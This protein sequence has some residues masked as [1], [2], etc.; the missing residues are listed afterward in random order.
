MVRWLHGRIGV[1]LEGFLLARSRSPAHLL[2]TYR[3]LARLGGRG[4]KQLALQVDLYISLGL[5]ADFHP[6]A[7][8]PGV[9]G[10]F[11]QLHSEAHPTT[12]V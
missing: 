10:Q 9:A 12:T 4:I 8:V 7:R 5:L 11:R 2:R 3:R 6:L 1:N